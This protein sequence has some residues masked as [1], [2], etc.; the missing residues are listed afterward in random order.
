MYSTTVL[1][2]DSSQLCAQL[3]GR[4]LPYIKCTSCDQYPVLK[5]LVVAAVEDRSPPLTPLHPLSHIPGGPHL[6]SMDGHRDRVS[7]VST[8]LV[9]GGG[10]SQEGMSLVIMTGSWDKT[11][12]SWDLGTSGV[13][14]TFDGHSDRVLS[15]A[16]SANGT[17]A[18]S[19]SDDKSVRY[20]S[21][22]S[23]ECVH[24]MRGHTA[25]VT[26]V[27]VTRDGSN[28]ISAS[29][30]A[31]VKFPWYTDLHPSRPQRPVLAAVLRG[32]SLA[33]GTSNGK[34]SLLHIVSG[35]VMRAVQGH[36]RAVTALATEEVEGH[37]HLVSGSAG[38]EVKVLDFSNL[39]SS[40]L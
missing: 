9:K 32:S 8:V 12:K 2:V 17:Y 37:C 23:A 35:Q 1:N 28:T 30:D 21:V 40:I 39:T 15:L 11:L 7:C 5:K 27:A 13:L 36:D 25:A 6:L 19:G 20:W 18:V 33:V 24:V 16:L 14:K 38:G 34:I 4:L 3:V 29:S 22:A 31:T 26:A 10:V